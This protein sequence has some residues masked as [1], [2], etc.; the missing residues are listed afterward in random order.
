IRDGTAEPSMCCVYVAVNSFLAPTQRY[1]GGVELVRAGGE[2]RPS[3]PARPTSRYFFV[4]SGGACSSCFKSR[5]FS[6][7]FFSTSLFV[8]TNSTR[9]FFAQFNSFVFGAIGLVLP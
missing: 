4:E 6:I 2:G 9:R 7:S 3:R 8:T 5:R 1:P